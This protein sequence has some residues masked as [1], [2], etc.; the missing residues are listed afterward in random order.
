[1]DEIEIL[2]ARVHELES[3]LSDFADSLVITSA[4]I[5]DSSDNDLKFLVGI[6]HKRIEAII[7]DVDAI[8]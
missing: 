6:A 1:M 5:E 2:K 4:L 3:K 7:T 8:L